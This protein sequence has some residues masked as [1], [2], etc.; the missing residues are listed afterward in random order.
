MKKFIF[1]IIIALLYFNCELNSQP[2][3]K[4]LKAKYRNAFTRIGPPE[5]FTYRNQL[6]KIA[7]SSFNVDYDVTVPQEAE[8]AFNYA[9]EI[10]S[11]LIGLS[12]P[13][14][15]KVS[16]VY[17]SGGMLGETSVNQFRN[18]YSGLPLAN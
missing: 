5:I 13:I 9:V 10:W 7:T 3:T 1:L 6:G 2:I 8:T 17:E 15:I 18:N 14:K 12:K 4:V 16:F 11:H